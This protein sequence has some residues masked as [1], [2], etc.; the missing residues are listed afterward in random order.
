MFRKFR[1]SAITLFIALPAVLFLSA[2]TSAIG[3]VGGQGSD[4][5][6]R[7]GSQLTL[8]GKQFRFAGTNNYY[9]DY[10]P[11]VMTNAVRD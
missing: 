11:N 3:C 8:H 10:S 1:L 7:Q 2:G 9:L 4:F 6:Q 5:V